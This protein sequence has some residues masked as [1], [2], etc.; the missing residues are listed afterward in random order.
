[1]ADYG[2]PSHPLYLPWE[3]DP[4]LFVH[5]NPIFPSYSQ[6]FVIPPPGYGWI[7]GPVTPVLPLEFDL[8]FLSTSYCRAYACFLQP[9][10]H[11]YPPPPAPLSQPPNDGVHL[12]IPLLLPGLPAPHYHQPLQIN[13]MTQIVAAGTGVFHPPARAG[14]RRGNAAGRWGIR[15]RREEASRDARTSSQNNTGTTSSQEREGR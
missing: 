5:P 13:V 12:G 2:Y 15:Q 10:A 3:F 1:M 8:A 4:Y 14:R 7:P 6:D 9:Y 11:H